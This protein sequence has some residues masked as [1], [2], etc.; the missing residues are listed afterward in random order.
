MSER[1]TAQDELAVLKIL[2]L[3]GPG[4]TLPEVEQKT[5]LGEPKI[6]AV[7]DALAHKGHVQRKA[8]KYFLQ[9]PLADFKEPEEQ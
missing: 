2:S 9:K 5:K 8:L 6:A 3:A 7:L 1:I 4:L